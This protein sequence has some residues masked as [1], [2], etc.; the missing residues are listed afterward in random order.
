MIET[1]IVWTY[2][3]HRTS[4]D[5]RPATPGPPALRSQAP[6][7]DRPVARNRD[8]GVQGLRDRQD[9]RARG[10][11]GRNHAGNDGT[12]ALARERARSLDLHEVAAS[13]GSW[14]GGH[15]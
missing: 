5:R 6:A 13:P 1:L 12:L 11:P 9:G 4:R 3:E 7:R 15:A 2:A 8:A 14:R 10:A